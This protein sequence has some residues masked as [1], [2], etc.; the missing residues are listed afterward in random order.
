MNTV[1]GLELYPGI[2]V[3]YAK[4]AYLGIREIGN[5]PGTIRP[6][7]QEILDKIGTGAIIVDWLPST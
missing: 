7:V 6:Q 3:L 4:H 1:T 2:V 5:L